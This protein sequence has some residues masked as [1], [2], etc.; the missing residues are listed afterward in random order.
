MKTIMKNYIME[1]R[2]S[3]IRAVCAAGIPSKKLKNHE[4][5]RFQ[6]VNMHSENQRI[7]LCYFQVDLHRSVMWI[8]MYH[9]RCKLTVSIHMIKPFTTLTAHL[10]DKQEYV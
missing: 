7:K 2:S 1:M 6:Y 3:L 5:D 9:K 8:A 10:S 4:V